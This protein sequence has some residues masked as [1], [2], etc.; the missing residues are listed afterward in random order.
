[1]AEA[2]G[3]AEQLAWRCGAAGQDTRTVPLGELRE[4]LAALAVDVTE[5]LAGAVRRP[6]AVV[7]YAADAA[8]TALGRDGTDAL[9]KVLRFGPETGVHVLGWWRGVQRLRALLSIS[10][11]V[12][13]LGA[14]VGLD[15]QGAELQG[16]VPGMLIS[17]SPR[18]G[19]GLFFDRAQH[20]VPEVVIVPS[21]EEPP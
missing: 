5:R 8:D 10:A 6:V 1:V 20:A 18:P 21:L 3:P 4:Q 12:D 7:L 13:D 9:R 2:V 16:L 19:R 14:W 17:W 15:V 11:S